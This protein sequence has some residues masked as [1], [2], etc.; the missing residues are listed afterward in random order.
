MKRLSVEN[1]RGT[2]SDR[3]INLAD[4]LVW[5]HSKTTK[6]WW[7]LKKSDFYQDLSQNI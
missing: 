7:N 5:E 4:K 2:I 1:A 6:Y 3:T